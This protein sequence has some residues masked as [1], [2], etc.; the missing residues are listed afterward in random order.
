MRAWMRPEI[1]RSIHTISP[2]KRLTKSR[3]ALHASRMP[4]V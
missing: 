1:R 3:T 4:T 2:A